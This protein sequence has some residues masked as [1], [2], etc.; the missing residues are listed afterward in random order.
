MENNYKKEDKS[1]LE[2]H[3][4]HT[5]KSSNVPIQALKLFISI[6]G[7]AD[8]YNNNVDNKLKRVLY[9]I[10]IP[11]KDKKKYFDILTNVLNVELK[12]IFIR[13]LFIN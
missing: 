8:D 11:S 12:E 9:K 6:P 3:F 10:T 2:I 7:F 4:V 5:Y 13:E 1:I